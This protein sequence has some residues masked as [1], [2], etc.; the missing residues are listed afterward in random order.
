MKPKLRKRT[1]LVQGVGIN[2]ADYIVTRK[3]NG[4]KTECHFYTSW[5]NMLTRCYSE[6][7]HKI[8]PTYID[9]T[10]SSE[11]LI[12]SRFKSWMEVQDWKGKHL[13]KD[14]LI[15]NNKVYSSST[16]IFVTRDVNTLLHKN[17]K[18]RGPHPIGVT[19]EASKY[20]AL[21]ST[22]GKRRYLGHYET[23]EEAHEAYKAFKYKYIAEIA[24]QQ[25]EPLRTA[26]LNYVIEP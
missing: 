20:K 2:D 26:L 18:Q 8:Q 6:T 9:C 24:S 3:V 11:W 1:K 25:S 7:F 16:C 17:L 15:K 22:Q 5:K 12:F 13:D 10:V 4:K 14:I 21:C 23:P 19:F